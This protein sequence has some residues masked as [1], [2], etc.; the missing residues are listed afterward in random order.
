MVRRE[1]I[2][3]AREREAKIRQNIIDVRI[4]LA[5]CGYREVT[6][7]KE[8][9]NGLIYCAVWEATNVPHGASVA[10]G[11]GRVSKD[12]QSQGHSLSTQVRHQLEL[13]AERGEPIRY[14]Y[15]DAGITGRDDRRPAFSR[16][17]RRATR[18]NICS[19][20]T[21][22][23]YRFYRNLRGLLTYF[24]I[25]EEHKV[26]LIST[27]D[28]HTD[29][30]S[31]DGKMLLHLKGII[32]ERFLDDL[33]RV[34]KDNKYAR[35]LKGYS[36]ASQAP[37][38]YCR[39]N[40]LDCTDPN[41]AGYCPRFGGPDLWR[42]LGDDPQVF[43]PHP[44]ESLALQLAAEW[45]ATGRYSDK[46]IAWM[47]NGERHELEDGSSVPLRPK[48]LP[49]RAQPDRRFHKD[50]VRDMLQNPYYAGWVTYHEMQKKKGGRF[51]GGKRHNRYGQT[52]S[53]VKGEETTPGK[54]ILL[55]GLHIPILDQDLF[56]R[57]LQ[58]RGA[59]GYLP[60]SD[61]GR[62]ARVYPLTGLLICDRDGGTFRGTAA[63]GDVRYY[64]DVKRVQ[65]ASDCPVRAVRAEKL[66]EPVFQYVQ[67]LRIPE[68]WHDQI[69]AYVDADDDGNNRRRQ[70]RSVESQ[71]H[72]VQTEYRMGELSTSEYLQVKRQ[73][74]Q[75]LQ[76]LEHEAGK[77]RGGPAA[78]LAD[79]DQ[80]WAMAT[81][82]EQKMLLN[83]VFF[84][85]RVRDGEIVSYMP[86]DPFRPLFVEAS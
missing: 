57:C 70:R 85:I 27:A 58:V 22:D 8:G 19:V 62:N 54:V 69:L 52:R 25:L 86:R 68:E 84:E 34:T 73:L 50:S 71:L 82:L 41:G 65:G 75:Q 51:Q 55:E 66:E 23:L 76:R 4:F 6:I 74:E 12:F 79:F 72:A 5:Q 29:F 3:S 9:R 47:L 63:H 49:G 38:G 81:P 15:I 46:D 53:S 83:C 2:Q 80:I 36:N 21:Y 48:G 17:I 59:K 30:G 7:F 37:F 40:C 14:F 61:A 32:G 28:R 39:G 18:G 56:D 11:Y 35:V 16:M 20:Y 31:S 13:A 43:C 67:Q 60:R 24:G 78:L 10:L 26:D 33:S 44:I 1:L 64:E 42:E 77:K 45:Y